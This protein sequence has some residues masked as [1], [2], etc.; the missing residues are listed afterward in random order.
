MLCKEPLT[1]NN[2]ASVVFPAISA[3]VIGRP[4]ICYSLFYIHGEKSYQPTYVTESWSKVPHLSL[5]ERPPV[6]SL[7]VKFSRGQA[8]PWS[9]HQD[10]W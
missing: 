1:A 10:G 2:P 9:N 8:V 5:K 3:V 7:G 4:I 6:N